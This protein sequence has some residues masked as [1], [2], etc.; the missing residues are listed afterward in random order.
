M[1][2]NRVRGQ[3]LSIF[4]SYLRGGGEEAGQIKFP[5]LAPAL[6]SASS[7]VPPAAALDR[8]DITRYRRL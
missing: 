8:A 7:A 3:S 6:L 1:K 2:R 5:G 4:G